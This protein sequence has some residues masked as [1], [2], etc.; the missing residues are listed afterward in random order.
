[1]V[2]INIVY[3]KYLGEPSTKCYFVIKGKV[4]VSN[5]ADAIPGSP[6][7]KKSSLKYSL[8][9]SHSINKS[10]INKTI[11]RKGEL[12]GNGEISSGMLR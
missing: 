11:Y 7:P 12:F 10:L 5:I 3:I 4:T 1:M 6:E 9:K 8:K 2:I